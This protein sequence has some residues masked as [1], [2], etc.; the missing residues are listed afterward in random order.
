MTFGFLFSTL[1]AGCCSDWTHGRS[2]LV[3]F[4]VTRLLRPGV[5][6]SVCIRTEVLTSPPRL[7]TPDHRRAKRFNAAQFYSCIDLRSIH[8]W[9]RSIFQ[10]RSC[11]LSTHQKLP[12]LLTFSWHLPC[13]HLFFLT[14]GNMTRSGAHVITWHRHDNTCSSKSVSWHNRRK[15]TTC[16]GC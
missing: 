7:Q 8:D 16:V 1:L 10:P 12:F 3:S 5:E 9:I 11:W 14:E 4:S 6:S 2:G 15:G 13:S